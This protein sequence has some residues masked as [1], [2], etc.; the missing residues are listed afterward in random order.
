MYLDD[1]RGQGSS[2]PVEV[3]R[4]HDPMHIKPETEEVEPDAPEPVVVFEEE[5]ESFLAQPIVFAATVICLIV[6]ILRC[7]STST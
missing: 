5:P 7:L 1:E 6:A 3:V 4:V 2:S